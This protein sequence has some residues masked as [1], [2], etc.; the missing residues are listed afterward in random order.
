MCNRCLMFS[1]S[2][3][4][5]VPAFLSQAFR[6]VLAVLGIQF[7]AKL[8]CTC[9]ALLPRHKNHLYA[10][11]HLLSY[12]VPCPCLSLIISNTQYFVVGVSP[13]YLY[14]PEMN[15]TNTVHYYIQ[16]NREKVRWCSITLNRPNENP[17]T[18]M[19]DEGQ[20]W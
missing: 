5:E 9:T 17:A 2:L 13:S 3:H 7:A 12:P 20:W 1:F 8:T 16:C 6:L 19:A 18:Q 15:V 4:K 11:P 10:A 14:K